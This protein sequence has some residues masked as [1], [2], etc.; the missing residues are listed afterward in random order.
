MAN[1]QA[2]AEY[3]IEQH[4]TID[5]VKA[6]T[7]HEAVIAE[8]RKILDGRNAASLPKKFVELMQ[9]P[10]TDVEKAE[11]DAYCRLK[12]TDGPTIFR[13]YRI[14]KAVQS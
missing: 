7:S 4:G 9:A 13:L 3:L 8:A 5:G 10:V 1:I 6:N 11:L 12:G 14:Y 2:V